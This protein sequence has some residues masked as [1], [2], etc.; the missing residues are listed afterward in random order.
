LCQIGLSSD[1]TIAYTNL[2]NSFGSIFVSQYVATIQAANSIRKKRQST[3]YSFT[4]NDLTTM[5]SGITS[6]TTSQ[7][8]TIST[9]AFYSCQSLIASTTGWSTSQLTVLAS[10]AKQV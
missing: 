3:S 1:S 6:L 7:L 4:C 2:L 5:G 8:N 9:S 10:I